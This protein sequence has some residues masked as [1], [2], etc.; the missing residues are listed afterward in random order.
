MQAQGNAKGGLIRARKFANGNLVDFSPQGTDTVPAVLTPGEFVIQKSAV[1]KY[2][3][4]MMGAINAGAYAQGG[5]VV[6][7]KQNKQKKNLVAIVGSNFKF[8]G[9]QKSVNDGTAII[10]RGVIPADEGSFSGDFSKMRGHGAF[11]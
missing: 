1:D 2:G 5:N 11:V 6:F 3:S 8:D 7:P 10:R 9:L 4:D